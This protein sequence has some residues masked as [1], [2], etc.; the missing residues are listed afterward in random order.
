METTNL[1]SQYQVADMPEH[2]IQQ[3]MSL[4]V[5]IKQQTGGNVVLIAYEHSGNQ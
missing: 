2:I 3:I 1:A 5:Q 4:E